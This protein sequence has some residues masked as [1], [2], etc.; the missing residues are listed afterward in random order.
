MPALL[1]AALKRKAELDAAKAAKQVSKIAT[2]TQAPGVPGIQAVE[3]L[4]QPVAVETRAV[5]ARRV[6][7]RARGGAAAQTEARDLEPVQ[8]GSVGSRP[9]TMPAWVTL[10]GLRGYIQAADPGHV[11]DK[12]MRWGQAQ[13][14]FNELMSTREGVARF[15]QSI[16][17][18]AYGVDAIA[19]GTAQGPA[20]R[21]K[22]RRH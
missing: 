9:F 7:S 4:A 2:G 6:A 20:R 15:L 11:G 17:E 21:R 19:P 16:A 5:K 3:V 14:R 1:E 8:D 18:V 22:S 13:K 10:D 12:K